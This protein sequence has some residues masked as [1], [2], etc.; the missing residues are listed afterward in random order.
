MEISQKS[1]Q[2]GTA[3]FHL[4][5]Q[6]MPDHYIP[7][8]LES[9]FFSK[10]L[11]PSLAQR[12]PENLEILKLCKTVELLSNVAV[13]SDHPYYVEKEKRTNIFFSG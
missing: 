2:Q 3:M 4:C 9:C 8:G 10:L 1:H 11:L 5:P 13:L 6:L 7:P 12:A